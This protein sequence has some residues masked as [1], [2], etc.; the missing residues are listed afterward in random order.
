MPMVIS[1]SST[2]IHLAKIG[3][4]D[5]LKKLFDRIV[6][7]PTVWQEVVE[8]GGGRA[9]ASE[10]SDALS[11]GWLEIIAPRD[12]ILFPLLK[13]EL[14]DGEAEVIALAVEC[15]ADMILLDESEARRIANIYDLS[16]TGVIGILIRAKRE[17]YIRSLKEELDKL[18]KDGGFWIDEAFYR[19]LLVAEEAPV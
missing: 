15:K 12:M 2:L 19:K 11:K 13:S 6:I 7:T 4:L 10:V 8:R 3:R 9:G 5:L 1:D 14:D 17:G 16:K 18:R